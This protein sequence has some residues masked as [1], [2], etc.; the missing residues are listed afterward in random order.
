MYVEG[1]IKYREVER[2]GIKKLFTNID[3]GYD[4]QITVLSPKESRSEQS[5]S[6]E[7]MSEEPVLE[8]KKERISSRGSR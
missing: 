6:Q 3:V 7:Q 4:G 8:K 5:N 1:K 2:D